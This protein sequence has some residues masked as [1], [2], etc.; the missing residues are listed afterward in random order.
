MSKL[1]ISSTAIEK[2]LD[3]VKGFVEK[4]AGGAIEEA[5][6][7][8]A[9]KVRLRRLRNQIKILEKA[10]GIAKENNI[11]TKQIN[12]KV[13]VP[14]LEYCSLEEEQTLQDMWANLIVNYSDS[15]KVYQSTI[16][17]FILSQISSDDAQILKRIN[18]SSIFDIIEQGINIYDIDNLLRLS[19]LKPNPILKMASFVDY[20]EL[21]PLGN[22]FMECCSFSGN[23]K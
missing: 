7:L 8:Y 5:G 22:K 6:L 19:L 16:F 1:D 4:L 12:L 10:K 18:D 14:L 21:S 3:M 11:E 23:E 13:L 20:Y 15:S 2:G 17:P 9:D